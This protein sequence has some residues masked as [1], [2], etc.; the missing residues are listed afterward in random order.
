MTQQEY[1]EAKA[2]L[3]T[4]F[5]G[6]RRQL[7]AHMDQLEAMPPLKSNDVQGFKKFADVVR[8]SVVKLQ[9]DGRDGELGEGTLYGLL[10]R[11]LGER[12]VEGYS[13]WL[14]ENKKE[15]E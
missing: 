3:H 10:V 7:R 15:R 4:K 6:K 14:K 9:V 5:D 13:R 1:E 8:I 12:Q 11:K 2:I